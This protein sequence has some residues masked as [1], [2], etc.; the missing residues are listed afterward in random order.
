MPCPNLADVKY[1]AFTEPFEVMNLRWFKK[2]SEKPDPNVPRIPGGSSG[3]IKMDLRES[4]TVGRRGRISLK[5]CIKP[6]DNKEI[7]MVT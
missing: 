4:D 2:V 6:F 5:D 1:T 7:R 3:S